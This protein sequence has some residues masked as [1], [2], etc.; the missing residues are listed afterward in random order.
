[1]Y[2][3]TYTAFGTT[4]TELADDLTEALRLVRGY[5]VQGCVVT[6]EMVG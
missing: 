2:H 1:M 4:T 3:V 5:L 6:V